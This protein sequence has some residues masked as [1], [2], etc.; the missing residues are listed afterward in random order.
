MSESEGVG[1]KW[2]G[3]GRYVVSSVIPRASARNTLFM[4][5]EKKPCGVWEED[6]SKPVRVMIPD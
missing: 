6:A 2:E 1:G 5:H 4:P 3:D